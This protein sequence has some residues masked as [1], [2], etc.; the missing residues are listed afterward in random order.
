MCYSFLYTRRKPRMKTLIANTIKRFL[1]WYHARCIAMNRAEI[2]D[3]QEEKIEAIREGDAE[4][5]IA[6]TH[7]IDDCQVSI[8]HHEEQ[9]VWLGA[10]DP[11]SQPTN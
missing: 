9:L 3:A 2:D 10:V 11:D 5:R 6:I 7:W 1:C 4:A 8:R